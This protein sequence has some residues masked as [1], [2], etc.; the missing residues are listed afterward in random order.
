MFPNPDFGSVRLY[1][2]V[3]FELQNIT[4]DTQ[5]TAVPIPASIWLYGI[6]ILGLVVITSGKIAA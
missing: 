6:G 3:E 5:S 4:I 2:P 1:V